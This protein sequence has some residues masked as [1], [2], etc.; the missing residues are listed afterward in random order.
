M[1]PPLMELSPNWLANRNAFIEDRLIRVG[2]HALRFYALSYIFSP[3]MSRSTDLA[4]RS[5][6]VFS[7]LAEYTQSM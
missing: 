1:Q 6:R 5:T 4:N 3:F 7:L 2:N